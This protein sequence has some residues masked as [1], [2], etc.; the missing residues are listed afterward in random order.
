[1]NAHPKYS[2]I[3]P[4]LLSL[5]GL[6]ALATPASAVVIDT[7]ADTF[8]SGDNQTTNYGGTTNL[9]VLEGGVGLAKDRYALIRF[10]LSSYTGGTVGGS[11]LTL[12]PQDISSTPQDFDIYGI[13]VGGPSED[14]DESTLTWAN[15]GFTFT[16]NG[17]DPSNLD[18]IGSFTE[19]VPSDEGVPQNLSNAALD[20]YLNS[21]LGN[22]IATFVIVNTDGVGFFN[23]FDSKEAASGGSTLTVTS[24]P[25]PTTTAL[26]LAMGV[27]ATVGLVR[28]RRRG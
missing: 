22:N 18:Y 5:G 12:I 14:F 11:T 27:F 15:S 24:V 17:L 1:M 7:A 19:L 9:N 28:K 10:D 16:S 21:K 26:A 2:K 13:P 20:A 8:I 6:L 3:S 23:K 4:A 25:E